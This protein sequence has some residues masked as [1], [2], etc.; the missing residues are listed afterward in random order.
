MKEKNCE[1]CGIPLRFI[2]T[3]SGRY[4]PCEAKKAS[5]IHEETGR[6]MKGFKTHWGDCPEGV[7]AKEEMR[8]RRTQKNGRS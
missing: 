8:A 7:A 5:F 4:M 2:P 6:L 3:D 1:F